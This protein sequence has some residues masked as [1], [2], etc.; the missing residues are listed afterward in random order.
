MRAARWSSPLLGVL[1]IAV[2]GVLTWLISR[3]ADPEFQK[4]PQFLVWVLLFTAQ[5]AIWVGGSFVV[6]R[7]LKAVWPGWKVGALAGPLAA[8]A[9]FVLFSL[10]IV[11]TYGFLRE[12]IPFTPAF[13]G[14]PDG[15]E[16]PLAHQAGRLT[17]FTAPAIALAVLAV[18]GLFLVRK[19]FLDKAARK[20]NVTD[21]DLIDFLRLRGR[22]LR[23]LAVIGVAIG[24]G[25]LVIGALKQAM[26]ASTPQATPRAVYCAKHKN[27]DFEAMRYCR[28]VPEPKATTRT[29][30]DQFI[31]LFGIYYSGL[32]MGA[33]AP[34]YVAFLTAGRELVRRKAPEGGTFLERVKERKELEDAL[35]LNV[36]AATTFK[37]SVAV[38]APLFG[39]LVGLLL[40]TGG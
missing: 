19:K 31:V 9:V 5:L 3:D 22:M 13:D 4:T 28:G 10:T 20:A 23:L 40:G 34:V 1:V 18:L 29:I 25:T 36:A 11:P 15:H 35:Q 6:L 14:L 32:L 12:E 27:D 30:D 39:S 7:E 16:W 37:S 2:A 26:D 17:V 33:F 38:F 21:S 8:A 24:I